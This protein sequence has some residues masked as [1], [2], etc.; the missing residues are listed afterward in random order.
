MVGLPLAAGW[1]LASSERWNKLMA[2]GWAFWMP[3]G[4]LA[5]LQVGAFW[6]A[7]HRNVVGAGGEWIRFEPLWQ[8]P[9]GWIPLI[10]AY[11][12]CRCRLGGDPGP[13][14]IRAL[15][16]RYETRQ[17]RSV[18]STRSPSRGSEL[19]ALLARAGLVGD[20]HL[21]DALA[22]A[23]HARRDLRLDRE[24]A[25]AELQRAEQLRAHDL[26]ARH[27]VRDPAVV[28]DVRRLGHGLVAHHV[29]EAERGMARPR[30]RPVD[31]AG[32]PRE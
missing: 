16:E 12:A 9:L 26:V 3:V 31:D 8:P 13:S 10:V 29:P 5:A 4:T 15:L 20:R 7:L 18:R 11:A 24:A 23:Q 25:L 14:R 27:H 6:W 32:L 2:A 19:L 22:R 1:V 28:E 17:R 21:V 30:P